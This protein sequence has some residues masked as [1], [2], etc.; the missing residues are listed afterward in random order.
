[1]VAAL[2][3]L[4]GIEKEDIEVFLGRDA[5]TVDYDASQVSLEDMYTAITELG[6]SPGIAEASAEGA[7]QDRLTEIPEPIASA[8]SDAAML[9]KL[10]FVDFFAEWCLACKVLEANVLNSPAVVSAL[11]DYL[12]LK[13]DT[14][15]YE[16]AAKYYK[17]VGMPTILVLD[18]AGEE[19]HRLVGL[20][21]AEEF[22]A[23]LQELVGK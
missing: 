1:M 12:V 19:V 5:F 21:D 4:A 7:A 8:L 2:S 18:T 11:D 10:V 6:Y 17:V 9:D 22:A 14:D 20:T 15:L 23:K 16:A 3:E 13:V